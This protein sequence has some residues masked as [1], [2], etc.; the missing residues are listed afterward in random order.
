MYNSNVAV[1]VSNYQENS[2]I[3]IEDIIEAY[4]VARRNKRRSPDQVGFE[5]H[6][7]AN[8]MQLYEQAVTRSVRP[9]AYTFVTDYPKPREVFASDM[10]T[11]VLHHYLD[12]RLRPLLEARMSPHTFNNRKGL[13]QKACQNAMIA[14]IYKVTEGFTRDAW[15][16]KLDLKG[17]FPNIN[18][19]IAYKQIEEV[20]LN[21]YH[22]YDKDELIYI[23][24][25]CIFS[26]PA[27]HCYRKSPMGKWEKIAPEKSVFN[28]P[29]G[30]AAAI[31]FL[32]WQNTVTYYF[33]SVHEWL[34]S[35]GIEHECYVDDWGFVVLNKEAFLAYIVPEFRK[36]L[37]ELGA[38]LNEKKFYCQHYTKGME[39]V[40]VHI[41][42]DRVHVNTRVVKRGIMAART[43]NRH[44]N[45]NHIDQTISSINSYLG[46]CKNVNGFNQ[47]K[48]IV[49][50]LSP[51]WDKY[52]TFNKERCCIQPLRPYRQR[53]RII[54]QYNLC[55]V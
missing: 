33:N 11:R 7:E 30:I 19:D 37:Q 48:D 32:I 42:L 2:M 8:C 52:I 12:I 31:G 6:W 1:P 18:Q 16:I 51:K 40:G 35:L 17:C 43:H 36:K 53:N 5:L 50:E 41:K 34:T 54:K 20:I 47:A 28:K 14:D 25:V 13:G 22:G 39:M 29:F 10:A 9:T 3:T 45:T 21:D 49:S 15:L 23:L 24:Q 44:I 26:Y 38:A 4:M 46:Q 27:L 55:N